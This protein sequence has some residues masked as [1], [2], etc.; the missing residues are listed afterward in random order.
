MTVLR[1]EEVKKLVLEG[2]PDWIEE[3][4]E[5]RRRLRET[6]G[7]IPRQSPQKMTYEEFLAWADEDTLA[8]W[9][10][11]EVVIYSPASKRHQNIADFLLKVMGTYVESHDLGMVISAPFQMKLEHGREPDV[12]FVTSEHL[13]RLKET[14]L[15]GPADLV[16]EIVS[17][18]TMGRDRGDKFYEYAQGG[19]PEYW[20]IDPQLQWADFY[21]LEGER[22]R[23]AFSG[24]EG[25]YRALVLPGFWLRVEWLWQEPLPHPL[26]ALAEIASVDT[27]VV[28]RFSQALGG[29]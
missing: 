14:Y 17:P 19:V 4:P 29:E 15:D 18:D 20:L 5:L 21:Q 8:E 12:L 26:R 7:E 1:A 3:H 2:L 11:G 9:V 13:D 28:E 22:Y 6:M 24:E 23:V 27:E 25:E 16:V 10:D